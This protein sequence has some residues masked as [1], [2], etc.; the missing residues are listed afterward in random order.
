[1]WEQ[2]EGKGRNNEL[3]EELIEEEEGK[4]ETGESPGGE[5]DSMFFF[6]TCSPNHGHVI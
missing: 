4:E 1:M 2:T 5:L 6:S 3:M